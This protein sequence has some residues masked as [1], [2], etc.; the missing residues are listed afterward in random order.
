MILYPAIDLKDGQ[1][2]R[3]LKGDMQKTTV[4]N[5]DPA[6]QARAFQDAGCAWLH[7][8]DLN[9]AFEGQPVN[10]AAVEA[11]LAKTD[12]PA[13]L[14]GGIRDMATIEMWLSRGI[15]RVILGT[16]AVED[17]DLVRA[18]ARAF[19]G[20]VAVGLDA[21]DGRV[22]TRG[23]AEET[24]MMVTDLAKSFE[25]AGVAAII[26]TDINRDG[27]MQGPN[28]AATAD[29]ARVTSI[30]VI[31]SGGVSSLADLI[32]LRDTGVIAGAISGRALYDGALDLADALAQLA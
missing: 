31:A 9:G 19:P 24:D 13:Q 18:A 14:G 12:V 21:R 22:A 26:Y 23:W 27:A 6:A 20:Q 29:L 30:P 16:V 4:F 17:P 10:G 32:A 3:L 5:D 25:D 1:A 7:L 15:A 11:I 8:V 2:V 28:V